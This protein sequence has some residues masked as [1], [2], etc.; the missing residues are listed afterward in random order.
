LEQPAAALIRQ[1]CIKTVRR[2]V[3]AA[4]PVAEPSVKLTNIVPYRGTVY[5][6]TPGLSNAGSGYGSGGRSGP[7]ATSWPCSTWAGC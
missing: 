5:H 6:R 1:T 7:N 3:R 2:S 4:C